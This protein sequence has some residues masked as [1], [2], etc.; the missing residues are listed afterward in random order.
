MVVLLTGRFAVAQVSL[1]AVASLICP[2]FHKLIIIVFLPLKSVL[3]SLQPNN[4]VVHVPWPIPHGVCSHW[5]LW[6]LLTLCMYHSWRRQELQT[7]RTGGLLLPSKIIRRKLK[8][9]KKRKKKYW[10]F[11][12]LAQDGSPYGIDMTKKMGSVESNGLWGKN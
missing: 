7:P 3:Y 8:K 12:L 10:R 5:I 2:H 4:S 11:C 1:K 9:K 6:D